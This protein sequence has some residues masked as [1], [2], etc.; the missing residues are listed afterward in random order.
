MGLGWQR[1]YHPMQVGQEIMN[2]GG[3]FRKF[4]TAF[5]AFFLRTMAFT[6]ARVAGFGYF[7]DWINSDPR[8]Q[9]RPDAYAMAGLL[10][11]LTLGITTNPIE[12]VFT[13]MQADEMYD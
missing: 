6:T 12:I 11:G 13:R 4:W 3:G 5:D 8:R 9:A 10:G 1:G 2:A 7:Y